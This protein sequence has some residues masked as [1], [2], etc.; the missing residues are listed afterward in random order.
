VLLPEDRVQ[1]QVSGG[2]PPM[3]NLSER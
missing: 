1:W 3:F 2:W